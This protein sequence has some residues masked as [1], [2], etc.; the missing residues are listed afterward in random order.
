MRLM[1]PFGKYS[2]E[3]TALVPLS[4]EGAPVATPP[5]GLSAREPSFPSATAIGANNADIASAIVRMF[6][7]FKDLEHVF[8]TSQS[9]WN[10]SQDLPCTCAVAAVGCDFNRARV[11]PQVPVV[12]GKV[13]FGSEADIPVATHHGQAGTLPGARL[14]GAA[15][16]K[17]HRNARSFRRSCCYLRQQESRQLA[18]RLLGNYRL[19]LWK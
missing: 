17:V 13:R 9:P 8:I 5:G 15:D 6:T 10:G 16:D 4:V 14:S 11:V 2:K 19:R 7:H 1:A 18:A 3:T 12:A